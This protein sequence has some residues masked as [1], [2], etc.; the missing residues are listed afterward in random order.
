MRSTDTLGDFHLNR[1]IPRDLTEASLSGAG[2]SILAALSMVFLFGMVNFELFVS[3]LSI[4][5]IMCRSFCQ[6]DIFS[7]CHHVWG[8][9]LWPKNNM[10]E[11]L[12]M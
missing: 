2:L 12:C 5:M 1:K 6:E 9:F 8:I 4:G 7:G 10:V 11:L 3:L